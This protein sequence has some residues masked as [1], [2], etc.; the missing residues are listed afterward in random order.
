MM[1]EECRYS[2]EHRESQ[3]YGRNRDSRVKR[4]R[5]LRC[6]IL[7]AAF[8]LGVSLAIGILGCSFLSKAQAEDAAV[9]YKYFTSVQV[10][11]GDTLLSI[12]QEYTDEHYDS[13]YAYMEE[14]CLTNHML[15]DKIYAGDYLIVPYYSTEFR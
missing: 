1:R 11:S 15:D 4:V 10:K 2:V 14:V 6:R 9:S 7:A 12:A 13:V 8:T 3:R 5:Q